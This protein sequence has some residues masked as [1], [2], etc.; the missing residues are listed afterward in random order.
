VD[1][2]PDKRQHPRWEV[3][4]QVF[5]YIDGARLDARSSNIGLGGMFIRTDG[6]DRVPLDFT[7]ILE[8]EHEGVLRRHIKWLH[9]NHLA[10]D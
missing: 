6:A 7:E 1:D 8:G 3:D 9:F 4:K 2:G 10:G 5:C